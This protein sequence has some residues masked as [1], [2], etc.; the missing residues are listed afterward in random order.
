MVILSG[1]GTVKTAVE[2][3]KLGAFDFIEKPPERDRIL[4][5]ARNAL[6][7]RRSREEN[8]RLKLSFDERY[9]MV[10][11]SAA[12]QKVLGRRRAAP[13]PPTPPSSSPARAA[14]ARSWWRG[15]STA[16]ASAR[17]RRSC[18]STARPSPRS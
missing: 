8:R 5:V 18:R 14:W 1:H 9:R 6:G 3:T 10:G 12:L 2:A 7:Q 13:R 4:L 17:T 15:P 16:T 11:E